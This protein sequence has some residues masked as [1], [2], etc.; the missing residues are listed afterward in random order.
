M[1]EALHALITER[2][3]VGRLF[4]ATARCGDLAHVSEA[5]DDLLA[6]LRA[7]SAAIGDEVAA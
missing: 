3:E 7:L 5:L 6:R 1:T 4:D 2:E